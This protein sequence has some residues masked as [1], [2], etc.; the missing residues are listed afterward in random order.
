MKFRKGDIVSLRGTVKHN[1]DPCDGEKD[2][3]VFV[4]IVGSHE[5]IWI[6]PEDLKLIQQVMEVGDSV[7]WPHHVHADKF[8]YGVILAIS[9]GHAW[10]DYGIGEYCTRTTTS[11]ERVEADG[12]IDEAIA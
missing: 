5:T 6:K 8:L 12:D 3:R 4:D 2:T 7:R 9:D 10:I 1:F 11:I